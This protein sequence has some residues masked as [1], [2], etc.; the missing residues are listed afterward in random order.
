[1]GPS[2]RLAGASACT[3]APD[4][5]ASDPL[6][7]DHAHRRGAA[8]VARS[9][10]LPAA[11][12]TS[13]S[14]ALLDELRASSSAMSTIAA[15]PAIRTRIFSPPAAMTSPT[16][17][18]A[19]PRRRSPLLHRDR[20]LH[21]ARCNRPAGRPTVRS[22]AV[23]G[24]GCCNR[25]GSQSP[26]SPMP[27][28]GDAWKSVCKR[29]DLETTLPV[30]ML[31]VG[32][33]RRRVRSGLRTDLLVSLADVSAIYGAT[34]LLALER[35]GPGCDDRCRNMHGRDVTDRNGS[36]SSALRGCSSPR[37]RLYAQSASAMA[38]TRSAWA[39]FRR[40]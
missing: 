8:I 33:I 9:L 30:L 38:A 19:S 22:G 40:T 26:W 27:F 37:R 21:S 28:A 32:G 39:K 31:P 3:P 29:V 10:R 35:V 11:G 2:T 25:W 34:H 7:A 16:R 4:L 12:G 15:W 20:L 24:A 17:A 13:M 23:S 18:A 6:R 1:M 5:P 36:C 14:D